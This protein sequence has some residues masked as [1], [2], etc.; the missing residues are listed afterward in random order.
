[1]KKNLFLIFC[2][3]LF[4]AVCLEFALRIINVEKPKETM[5]AREEWISVPER[6]W[7]TYHPILGWYHLTNKQSELVKKTAVS[8]SSRSETASRLALEL[9]T[10]K[11]SRHA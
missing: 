3:L 1:M 2:S 7:T 11:F 10:P 8:A 5:A 4:T 6:V 9:L